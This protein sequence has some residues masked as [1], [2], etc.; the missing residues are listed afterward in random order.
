M[1]KPTIAEVRHEE[2]DRDEANQHNVRI[3]RDPEMCQAEDKDDRKL[4]RKMQE[5]AGIS[6]IPQR[7]DAPSE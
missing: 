7:N 2:R 6:Q 3:K 1:F 5:V 4:N